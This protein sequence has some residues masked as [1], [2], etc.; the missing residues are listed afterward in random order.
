MPAATI[1]T[2]SARAFVVP[3]NSFAYAVKNTSDTQVFLR[4]NKAVATSGTDMGMPLDPGEFRLISF[5]KPLVSDLSILGIHAGSG[6]KTVAWEA[7]REPVKAAAGVSSTANVTLS[8]GDVQIGAIELKNASDDTRAAVGTGGGLSSSSNALAVG[9]QIGGHT[10]TV[11]VTFSLDT[12]AYASGDL[13]AETQVI[14]A[15]MR[16]DDKQGLLTGFT[17]HDE[18]DQGIE[19]DVVLLSANA[20]L[21]TENSAVSITDA[22]AREILGIVNVGSSDWKDLGGV[23][24]ATKLNVNVPIKPAT[25]TDDCYVAL[26]TRGA[27]T[28][29]GSGI[30]GRFHFLQD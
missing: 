24:V 17:L 28:H 3:D 12:S 19:L 13:L 23:R 4:H 29:T 1:T 2:S 7:F 9:G 20:S 27:P 10:K 26:I 15:C 11:D 5:E 30:R 25:G 14:A 8:A 16:L 22:N 21:G 6:S 18:D